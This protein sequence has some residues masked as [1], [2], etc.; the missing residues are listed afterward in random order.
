MRWDGDGMG[1]GELDCDVFFA[2]AFRRCPSLFFGGGISSSFS[3]GFFLIDFIRYWEGKRKVIIVP[4][5]NVFF[6]VQELT[7][8]KIILVFIL[9][10]GERGRGVG[11]RGVLVRGYCYSKT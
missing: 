4:K 5:Q 11:E 6:F 1:R 10:M 2:R 8:R 7:L 9:G 3:G